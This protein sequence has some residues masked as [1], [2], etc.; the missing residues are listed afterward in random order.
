MAKVRT[1]L[2]RWVDDGMKALRGQKVGL[3]GHPASV[4][5]DV[6]HLLDRCLEHDVDLVRLFGP[7]HG[8]L[9]DAQD[10]AG[11]DGHTDR[12]SGLE[13]VSLY[14]PTRES[15]FLQPAHL[16]GIDVLIC[17]LQDIGSRYYTYAYTVA[18]AMRTCAELGKKVVVFDRPNPIG[19]TLVEGNLVKD[20]FRSFVGEYAL[21]NRTG[22]TLGELCHFFND[23]DEGETGRRCELEV[24]WCDGYERSMSHPDTGLPWVLPS[25][26]MP[27]PDTALVYPG[28]CLFE[29][30]NLSEGRGTTRPFELVGAPYIDDVHAY[31][32][33]CAA[34]SGEGVT[35]RPCHFT[36][37]FQK[38]ASQLC[39]GVQLHVTDP[40]TFRPLRAAVA[41]L[42]A[43]RPIDGFGWR[44]EVYEF[45]SDRYAID[46]L[47][48]DDRARLCIDRGGSTDDVMAL[49]DEDREAVQALHQRYQHGAY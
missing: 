44:E 43:A 18:F 37:T 26:N 3:L 40:A 38:H 21:P 33:A 7:E 15:L 46:I 20:G 25:P 12:R 47:F 39:G 22:L 30:T 31:A 8:L 19:G 34:Q 41:M 45:V 29:G 28:G 4:D 48:G 5:R 17:D 24:V 35:F 11:V 49:L 2:D 27:T 13:V 36:P 16:D 9:G 1:G 42:V 6:V 32:D 23:I 10:M 14:G